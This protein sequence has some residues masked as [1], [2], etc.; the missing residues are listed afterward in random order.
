MTSF[1]YVY[2]DAARLSDCIGQKRENIRRL[3]ERYGFRR[4]FVKEKRSD[5]EKEKND[6]II[7][8]ML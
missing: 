5:I 8:V 7:S 6:K 2:V 4:I 1:L 3:T